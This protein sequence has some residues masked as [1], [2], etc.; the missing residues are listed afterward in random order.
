PDAEVFDE[1][2]STLFQSWRQRLRWS[3]GYLQV[4]KKYGWKLVKG[5]FRGSFS[6]YDMTMSILPAFLLT[7]VSVAV[8]FVAAI[9]I[10]ASGG[11]LLKQILTVLQVLFGAIQAVFV[12]GLVS[13]ITEWHKIKATNA[14]KIAS[15]FTL[16]LFMLTYIPIAIEA[17][18]VNPSWKPIKHSVSLASMEARP[19]E[20]Q[21]LK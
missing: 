9:I 18:F 15:I 3:R 4:L 13:C 16:P 2:T 7:T 21:I 5:I 1:Q 6:C 10:I 8:N 19:D 20:E 17:L 12:I 14:R 11:D